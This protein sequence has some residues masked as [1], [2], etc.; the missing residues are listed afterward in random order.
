MVWSIDGLWLLFN[1]D[2]YNS[3]LISPTQ[4]S[5][6]EQKEKDAITITGR[7]N[8]LN[9]LLFRRHSCLELTIWMAGAYTLL[10]D[11]YY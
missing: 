10:I 6:S 8:N 5:T 2:S 11:K 7:G 9:V 3:I 4:E 1:H